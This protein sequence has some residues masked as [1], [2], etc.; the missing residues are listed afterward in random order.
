MHQQ[1]DRLLWNIQKSC[2]VNLVDEIVLEDYV[3]L[4]RCIP[5][6]CC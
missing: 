4:L 2:I 5:N 3:G 6:L 1:F